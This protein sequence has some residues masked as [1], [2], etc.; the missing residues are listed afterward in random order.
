M[1]HI[2]NILSQQFPHFAEIHTFRTQ[3]F[4]G[5]TVCNTSELLADQTEVHLLKPATIQLYE[6]T[7]KAFLNWR[8]WQEKWYPSSD[9]Q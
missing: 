8:G 9:L 2:A 3:G 5:V 4:V 7:L 6:T 1:E